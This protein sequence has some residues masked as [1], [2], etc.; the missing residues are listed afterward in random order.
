MKA[1]VLAGGYAKRLW[2]L[3]K[4]TPKPLLDVGGKEIISW[5]IE[6]ILNI[7]D[8]SEIII[9]TNEKYKENFEKYINN[10]NFSKPVKLICEPI[11]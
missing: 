6:K 3:T 1:I 4:N 7:S 9:S 5:I 2:P 8:I 10:R 11:L